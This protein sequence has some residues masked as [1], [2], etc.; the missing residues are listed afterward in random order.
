MTLKDFTWG[1]L[2]T[3]L[4]GEGIKFEIEE[5]GDIRAA[6]DN[7]VVWHSF[8]PERNLWD[9]NVLWRGDI[10]PADL[11]QA[12][13]AVN[14]WN[15]DAPFPK[16]F[17]AL[18]DD[19]EVWQLRGEVHFMTEHKLTD[20]QLEHNHDMAMALSFRLFEQFEN[21]FPHLVTWSEED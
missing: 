11:A 20:E 6:W 1:R 7:G 9:V 13:R 19:A 10:P 3:Y 12:Q 21:G 18:L 15:S 8:D 2:E 5:D 4:Q 16:V 14:K 17:L